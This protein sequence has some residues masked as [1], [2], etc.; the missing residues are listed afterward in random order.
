MLQAEG[1]T[2]EQIDE[3]MIRFGF[4]AGLLALADSSR[5]EVPLLGQPLGNTHRVIQDEEIIQRIVLALVDEGAS[6]LEEGIA[7][8][9]SEVDVVCVNGFGFPAWRGGPMFY[10]QR[11]GWPSMLDR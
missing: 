1:A 10:A 8:L 2:Q 11:Q 9:A 5:L 4:D 6:M 7:H 3:A